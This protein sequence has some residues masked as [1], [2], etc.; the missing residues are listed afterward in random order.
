[1]KDYFMWGR[2]RRWEGV[3]GS[4]VVEDRAQRK[5]NMVSLWAQVHDGR[6]FQVE[7]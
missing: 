5:F 2:G 1:M 3:K 6:F 7:K 4:K